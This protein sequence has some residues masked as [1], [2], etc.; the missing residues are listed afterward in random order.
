MTF[1]EHFF[2]LLYRRPIPAIAALYW[3]L[4]RRKVRAR[5]RLLGASADMPFAYTAWIERNERVA[6]LTNDWQTLANRWSKR[7]RF[8]IL[9]HSSTEN[10]AKRRSVASLQRQIYPDWDLIDVG[11]EPFGKFIS[12]S[13]GDFVVPLHAGTELSEFALFRFAEA[14]HKNPEA[15][16]LYGDE[17]NLS[18]RGTRSEPWFKPQW[19]E[20]LFL[21]QDYLS[22]A[23]AIEVK[24]A[25]KTVR[26]TEGDLPSMLLAATSASSTV[27][28]V[29]HI[30]A[31]VTSATTRNS[32]RLEAVRQHLKAR[33]ASCVAGPYQSVKV[34]W[35]LP[36]KLP[37]V[38]I[39]IPTRDKLDLLRPCIESL[40]ERTDYRNLEV[41][42]VD[43]GSSD[44]RTTEYLN[45]IGLHPKVRVLG[46]NR[47]F[48]YS[49]INNFAAGQARGTYL[50]LLNN[51]TEVIEPNWL[52]ELMRYAVRIDIGAAGAKLLYDDGSIQ[53]AGVVVGIGEAAGH[54]H[55]FLPAGQRGYFA[56][57]H[58]PQFVSAVTGAC[59]LVEKS[60]FESVGGLDEDKLQVAFNDVDLCMKLEA[61]GWRNVYVPHAV[62][63]HHE[64]KSRGSDLAPAHIERYLRELA[65]LQTRWRTKTYVDPLHNPNLDRYSE[66]FVFRV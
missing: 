38:S 1:W 20:E 34:E 10:A 48:N 9:L 19:N 25:C 63:I 15:T 60:K 33:G 24:L 23:V 21:A 55:R 62:L 3:Y 22:S 4:T 6:M 50:C 17:D 11:F 12:A 45:A 41:L 43:N 37:L 27:I 65:V 2:R 53:H 57:P 18:R 39:I 52:T 56:M 7:P 30:L 14:L 66:T 46:Y 13:M 61:A 64:S 42:I 36:T 5:N 16:V 31:H 26:K 35:A 47:P 59:L 49:A 28:H 44:P 32:A 51:D 40:L 8:S 29:P 58:L 54:A